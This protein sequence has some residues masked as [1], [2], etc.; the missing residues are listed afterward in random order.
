MKKNIIEY[1][2]G[3]VSK[4]LW[5]FTGG[6]VWDIK[7][8]KQSNYPKK[9]DSAYEILKSILKD[10]KLKLS[11]YPEVFNVK[12]PKFIFDK[13]KKE[14]QKE[15]YEN[16]TIKAS[17]V[18]CLADIPIQHLSYHAKRYSKFAIGFYRKSAVENNF[19]PVFYSL[20]RTDVVNSIYNSLNGLDLLNFDDL[21][22]RLEN[23]FGGYGYDESF[24]LQSQA[25]DIKDEIDYLNEIK[26]KVEGNLKRFV[27][28]VK[29]FYD[30]E[31]HTIL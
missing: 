4:I 13:E 12:V 11:S 25:S 6:P 20:N 17:P 27:S 3:T 16:K 22:S 5:H 10:N 21:I 2:S 18:C 1:P 29:T 15:G 7:K 23:Y 26:E 9:F 8:N 19:N 28:F 30:N 14:L 31:F 24:E